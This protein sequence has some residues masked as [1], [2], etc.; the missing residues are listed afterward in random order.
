MSTF[1]EMIKVSL[2]GESHG[3]MIGITIHQLPAGLRLPIKKISE[4]LNQRRGS[5]ALSTPRRE[6]DPFEIISGYF[7]GYTTGAP[8]TIVIPNRDTRS[9]DYTP[10]ILR[11]SH[12]D[13]SAWEK[14][15]G[16]QDYRGGGHFSGRLTAMIVILGAISQDILLK[17]DIHIA[18]HIES[19][20]KNHDQS[21]PTNISLDLIK[22][23]N[24]SHFPLI[25]KA[26]E[27][28]FKQTILDAKEQRDSVGGV[29]ETAII[30]VPTGYGNPFFDSMESILSHLIFSVPAV[31]G[32]EFGEG[33]N[34]TN[35]YGSETND[36]IKVQNDKIV[37]TT[38]H[39]GGIQGG[40]TNGMPITFKVA[41]KPTAS[42]GKPQ[43][44]ANIQT[45]ENTTLELKGRHDPSI[46]PRVLPVINAI[47]AYGVLEMICRNEGTKWMI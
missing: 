13:Y 22:K 11:P 36:P 17:K 23:L 33:F 20:H 38:N 24:S 15:H 29:I 3:K 32:L 19:I 35:M 7:K 43:A 16:Y 18:S 47:T 28:L 26:N 44:T 12:A 40:I 42:I 39:S 5:S 46:V 14:Y 45:M 2:F 8:L 10:E 34:I 4:L 21:F 25:D 30:N 6:P 31:K 1:G 9:K 41:I 37:M 27:D